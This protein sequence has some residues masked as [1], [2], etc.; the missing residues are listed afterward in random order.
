MGAEIQHNLVNR[1]VIKPAGGSVRPV[2]AE[3]QPML[4]IGSFPRPG[5]TKPGLRFPGNAASVRPT[6]R[7]VRPHRILGLLHALFLFSGLAGLGCQFVW[8]RMF[9]LGLGQELPAMLAVVAAFFGG[10]ALGA[11]GLDGSV[12]TSR[13]PGRWYA[14]LE[15]VI[16]GWT[17]VTI[18]LVP[19]LNDCAPHWIG[20]EPSPQWQWTVAFVLPLVGLLPATAAMGATL[21]AIERFASRWT[22]DS[23]CVGS[24]YAVNTLGATLGAVL[25]AFV[26]VPLLGFPGTLVLLAIVSLLCAGAMVIIEGWTF[27]ATS[28]AAPVNAS[29]PARPEQALPRD[30]ATAA[31]E[32][33]TTRLFVT[34][35]VTGLLGIGFEVLGVRLL[36][37]VLEDTVFTFATV[38]AIYLL[39][40]AIGAAVERH[41]L[42][43]PDPQVRLGWLL[44]SLAATIGLASWG[45]T[46]TPALFHWGR[47][48]F[49][50]SRLG[51]VSAEALAATIV[52]AL[53]T[54]LM[55]ATF[56]FL[57][58][59]ARRPAGGVG[60]ALAWNTLGAALAPLVVV[61]GLLPWLGG[62]WTLATLAAGY[63]ALI[64]RWNQ[65]VVVT[66]ALA[67]TLVLTLP[68]GLRLTQILPGETILAQ[69]E[70][71]TQTATVI[72][73]PDGHRTLRVNH[74]FTMGG[75]AA[76]AAERL[77]SHL[78]LLLHPAPR[79]ALFLG[80]GTGISFGAM[81][82]H[83]GLA[84]DGVELAPE[85]LALLPEFAPAND[86][87]NWGHRL[88]TVQADAR[89]FVRTGTNTY[90]VIVADLFHPARDGAGTLYTREHFLA[91]RAR[92]APD[93]LF[94][95]WLPLYQLDTRTLQI[96]V[97]TFLEV[98]PDARAWLLR[99]NQDT[100]VI[101]LVG[102]REPRRYP[103]DWFE[104]R[105]TDASL[106]EALRQVGLPDTITLLGRAL[107]GP[108]ALREFSKNMPVNTDLRP[109]VT[110]A[111]ARAEELHPSRPEARLLE[112]LAWNEARPADPLVESATDE[113]FA[114]RLR[115]Y[116]AAR[117]IY[118][119]GL[120]D[121]ARGE[122]E[123]AAANFL[124]SARRSPDFSTGYA[125][126]LTL[127]TQLAGTDPARAA[128]LL[129]E[130]ATAR[131]ERPVARELRR[132]LFPAAATDTPSGSGIVP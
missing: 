85:V 37:Q 114:D 66:A 25:G 113:S 13:R 118:L 117:D 110:F 122:R 50:N 3:N 67:L 78:P 49:G 59:S 65:R 60:R 111:A 34:L 31:P 112:L 91:I 7:M 55:G 15:G 101:G 127:A 43:A 124:A 58:R 102:T 80:V 17:A 128:A 130:L 6:H 98:F 33:T 90:D 92:L 88:T 44:A 1:T 41:L 99:F 77:H 47:V 46:A 70:G 38:L 126:C 84:A 121:E 119:A 68:A 61:V 30:R 8:I 10:F 115:A 69:R 63:L 14:A 29:T 120:R 32:S 83:P 27:A 94:C 20:L 86:L 93:G 24:L 108:S 75:T 109:Q 131:P 129:A 76:A 132:R 97:R 36:R 71:A 51:T 54:L 107:L 42:P 21:P 82:A 2:P 73:T 116:V 56:S 64:P 100:P 45:L 105:V 96:V 5:P 22:G 39:G 106:R 9:A 48:T 16:G 62:H 26:L 12:S 87:A 53:P 40:T 57:A 81:A 11:A 123:A 74:R 95:Q 18:V 104:R 35:F 52:F 125:H 23:R 89:R 19:W 72:G 4:A 28:E 79:R 103:A